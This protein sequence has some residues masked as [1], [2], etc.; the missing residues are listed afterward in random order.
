MFSRHLSSLIRCDTY[1][2]RLAGPKSNVRA[3]CPNHQN[4][5]TNA[6]RIGVAAIVL[7]G[8]VDVRGVHGATVVA[9]A[10]SWPS[11]LST[12][13][14]FS[15]RFGRRLA[16]DGP[17]VEPLALVSV[18][19]PAADAAAPLLSL[20]LL[21]LL[22][23]FSSALALPLVAPAVPASMAAAVAIAVV[24]GPASFFDGHLVP[25]KFV[26]SMAAFSSLADRSSRDTLE[27]RIL[28]DMMPM[29]SVGM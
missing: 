3:D 9:A 7:P 27:F 23:E 19:A 20:L 14:N 24:A 26:S 25:G 13:P 2:G 29:S 16:A 17:A 1:F 22:F 10:A 21:L 5:C 4:Y 28:D 18:A 15:A 11:P 8:V 12:V 6:N